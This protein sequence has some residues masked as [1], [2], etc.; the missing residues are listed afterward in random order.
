ML[1]PV[2]PANPLVLDVDWIAFEVLEGDVDGLAIRACEV[3]E[4]AN[5]DRFAEFNGGVGVAAPVDAAVQAVTKTDV[6]GE[7][8]E[9]AVDG[10][11]PWFAS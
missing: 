4:K 1:R 5:C 9:F 7:L 10:E 8:V 6:M 3:I 2:P 11:L